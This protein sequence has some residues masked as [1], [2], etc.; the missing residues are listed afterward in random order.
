MENNNNNNTVTNMQE[1]RAVIRELLEQGKEKGSLIRTEI[2]EE[3]K[4][5][6]YSRSDQRDR[7]RAP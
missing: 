1:K 6:F 3:L 2:I 4:I 7:G 5:R